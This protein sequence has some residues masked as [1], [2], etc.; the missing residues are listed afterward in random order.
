ML[1][2]Y[3]QCCYT[4][5]HCAVRYYVIADGHYAESRY[6]ECRGSVAIITT[7]KSF[8]VEVPASVYF[9]A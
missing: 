8:I 7:Q 9:H 2:H 5:C 6:A 3:A 1:C 4:E